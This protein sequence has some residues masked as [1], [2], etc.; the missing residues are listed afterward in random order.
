[1]ILTDTSKG[2][3]LRNATYLKSRLLA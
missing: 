1:M 3:V 2:S